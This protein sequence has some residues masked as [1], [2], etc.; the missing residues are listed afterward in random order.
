[1]MAK[2]YVRLR[3][4]AQI[5]IDPESAKYIDDLSLEQLSNRIFEIKTVTLPFKAGR[6]RGTVTFVVPDPLQL[7]KARL[8]QLADQSDVHY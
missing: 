1:M 3:T 5:E 7:K 6:L 2:N 4:E 8:A